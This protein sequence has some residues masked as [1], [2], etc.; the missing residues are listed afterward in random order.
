MVIEDDSELVGD[1]ELAAS[2]VTAAPATSACRRAVGMLSLSASVMLCSAALAGAAT[3]V[4]YGLI[5]HRAST[6]NGMVPM[7]VSAYVL[8]WAGVG[9]AALALVMLG[10]DAARCRRVGGVRTALLALTVLCLAFAA[11]VTYTVYSDAP[12]RRFLC[13]G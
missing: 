1:E 11:F 12:T 10:V 7:P 4:S 9:T 13:S 2:V 5:R 3:Q 6:C 8:G